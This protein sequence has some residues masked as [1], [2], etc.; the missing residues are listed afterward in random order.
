MRFALGVFDGVLSEYIC[1]YNWGDSLEKLPGACEYEIDLDKKHCEKEQVS[2]T[3]PNG[4]ASE[5]FSR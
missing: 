5:I 4:R 2:F 1:H 3:R